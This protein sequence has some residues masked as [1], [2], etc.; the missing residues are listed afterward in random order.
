MLRIGILNIGFYFFILMIRYRIGSRR[1]IDELGGKDE[2]FGRRR[3]K[4]KK[5]KKKTRF[6]MRIEL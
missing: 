2:E 1:K 6:E 5:M 4:M 3:E